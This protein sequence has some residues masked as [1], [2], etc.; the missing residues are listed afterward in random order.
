MNSKDIKDILNIHTEQTVPRSSKK[1]KLAKKPAGLNRELVWKGFESSARND[2]LQFHHW[3]KQDEPSSDYYYAKFNSTFKVPQ[4]DPDEYQSHFTEYDWTFDETRYLFD[5]CKTFDLR[6]QVI[7]DRYSYSPPNSEQ[8]QDIKPSLNQ[9]S[10]EDLKARYYSIIKKMIE[11]PALRKKYNILGTDQNSGTQRKALA[12]LSFDKDK[13]TERKKLLEELL[14]RTTEEIEEERKLLVE[15]E[16]IQTQQKKLARERESVMLSIVP[17]EET[18]PSMV[19]ADPNAPEPQQEKRSSK[20]SFSEKRN[21]GTK[22]QYSDSS[23]S[24]NIINLN[25]NKSLVEINTQLVNI[26]SIS[27]STYI[28]VRDLKLGPGA[29]LRSEKITPVPKHRVEQVQLI[30]DHLGVSCSISAWPRPFMPTAPICDR[31][32]E[33]IQNI[34][35]LLELKKVCDKTEAELCILESRKNMLV[36][37]V[38]QKKHDL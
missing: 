33:I 21:D 30:L 38:E 28:P 8:Q 35:P 18:T 31:F 5:L 12:L 4:L 3:V 14:N 23:E 20:D 32:E 19:R 10:I 26:P 34:V 24:K 6:F 15:L 1:L 9:R 25:K 37:E 7:H 17:F 11:I 27:K 13:E 29:F 16:R 2:H 36:K 22:K